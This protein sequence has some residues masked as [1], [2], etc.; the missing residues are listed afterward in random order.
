MLLTVVLQLSYIIGSR[1]NE[2]Q[3]PNM[4]TEIKAVLV[5]LSISI[6][7]NTRQ[8]PDITNEVR[9]R[10]KLGIG[11]GKWVRHIFPQEALK[12]IRAKGGVFRRQHYDLT[13]PWDD[14]CRLLP[15]NAHA[16][17][18]NQYEI[19]RTNYFAA[20]DAFGNTYD[21]WCAESKT[22]HGKSF[23]PSLYPKWAKMRDLF[24]FNV[25][26]LPMPKASHFITSGI[27]ADAVEEMR[28][29]LEAANQIRV[30]AAVKDIWTR[31][32][33]PVK[34]IADA[35]CDKETIFRDTLVENV[36]EIVA[37]VPSLNLTNDVALRA[38]A[39]E[40]ETKFSALDVEALRTNPVVRR[41]VASQAKE[42]AA[43]F[44]ALGRRRFA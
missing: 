25:E 13:L 19:G 38:L 31:L 34:K 30:E 17:Y 24:S 7:A 44:G 40:I 18:S 26:F 20:R 1:T 4:P 36:K 23:D 12:D 42:I 41:E 39:T 11:A 15:A 35:L 27:A 16:H 33:E 22:M 14:G 6:F 9:T 29:S 10:K 2:A 3:K 32:L 37:L 28:Q 21:H 43:R 8:D 5:R